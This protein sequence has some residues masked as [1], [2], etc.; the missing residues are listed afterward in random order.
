MELAEAQF[1]RSVF[2]SGGDA[3]WRFPGSLLPDGKYR[4]QS[5]QLAASYRAWREKRGPAAKFG[6]VRGVER[7][8][9]SECRYFVIDVR[10][11]CASLGARPCADFERCVEA[12]AK[13]CGLARR[14]TVLSAR[15]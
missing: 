3:Y 6:L 15:S 9:T 14:P 12:L 13:P 2:V 7:A 8:R 5:G 11:L 1:L 4:V 10:A